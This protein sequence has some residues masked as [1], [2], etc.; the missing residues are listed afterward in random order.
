VVERLIREILLTSNYLSG[1]PALSLQ[2]SSW[3]VF[4]SPYSSKHLIYYCT[5][6]RR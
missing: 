6:R 5:G 2:R 3:Y 1:S 4:L